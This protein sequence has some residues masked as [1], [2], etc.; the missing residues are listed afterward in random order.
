LLFIA[1]A[2]PLAFKIIISLLL[3]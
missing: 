2:L 3:C 1:L